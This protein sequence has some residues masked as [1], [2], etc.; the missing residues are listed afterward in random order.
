MAVR[1]RL[2][3]M[4]AKKKPFY[5][6]VAADTRAPRDG[7]IIE[8]LGHYDPMTEPPVIVVDLERV[9][10]WIGVG[11]TPSDTVAQLIG[12]ARTAGEAAVEA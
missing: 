9:D 6:I 8:K 2:T 11:A 12:K 5:R 10:Y 1:L 4:G 3:R 7:R